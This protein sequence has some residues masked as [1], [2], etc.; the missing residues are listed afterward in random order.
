[1]A[2]FQKLKATHAK[3]QAIIKGEAVPETVVETTTIAPQEEAT[4]EYPLNQE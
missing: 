3:V 4:E 2:D 1:M